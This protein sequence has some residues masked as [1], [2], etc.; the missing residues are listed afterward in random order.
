MKT[1]PLLTILTLLLF[2]ANSCREELTAPDDDLIEELQC[3]DGDISSIRGSHELVAIEGE[4]AI[5]NDCNATNCPKFDITFNEDLTY[6]LS[7]I[8]YYL[9][10]DTIRLEESGSYTFQCTDRY[11]TSGRI[12]VEAT[13]G[14]VVLNNGLT[15]KEMKPSLSPD[16]ALQLS[17]DDGFDELNNLTLFMR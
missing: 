16:V 1:S 13:E 8:I 4:Y 9:G 11:W 12:V 5:F 3:I 7:A 14:N 2:L 15:E 10:S 6:E 17:L